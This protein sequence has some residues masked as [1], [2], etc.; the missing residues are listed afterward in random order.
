MPTPASGVLAEAAGLSDV[1]FDLFGNKYEECNED[2]YYYFH[3][4]CV[5]YMMIICY[6]A[7]AFECG[8]F[9]FAA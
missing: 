9:Y 1:D 6:N 7:Y 5:Y 4:I 2:V 8:K 3:G